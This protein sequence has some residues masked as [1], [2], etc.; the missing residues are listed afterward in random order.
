MSVDDPVGYLERLVQI[1]SHESVYEVRDFLTE[2]IEN[3]RVHPESGCVVATKGPETG[4]PHV[5]LNSHMDV[6]PPHLEYERDGN[7]L[8][9]RGVC[10]A[11]GSLAP[12]VAA[13][14]R[15]SPDSGKV[16]LV[17][18]PDEE[19]YSEG[20]YDFLSLEGESGDMAI[21]GEPTGLDVCNAARGSLKYV[22]ELEGSAA[23]AG[24]KD[25]GR[26]AVSCAAD[27]VGRLER[28][29]PL[30]DDY[31]GSTSQTVSWIEGGPV[32]EYTSQVPRQVRLFVNR[33]SVPPEEPADFKTEIEAELSDLDC[34]VTVRY[35]YQPNRFLEAFRVEPDEPVI[36]DLS[37]AVES[38][39]GECP[40]VRPFAVAAEASF[41]ARYMPVAIFG[42][43]MSM[44]EE[45]PI[46][47]SDREY[48]HA[49]EVATAADVLT[50]YLESTV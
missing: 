20:L 17:V 24:T 2:T 31:L 32:G 37:R 15:V 48:I 7:V 38:V 10:D 4:S 13:F 35:P 41:F 21:N 33:W 43:G 36:Q 25:S 27:A 9:G 29:N 11:K 45:G 1:P 44:D 12:L 5:F 50:E 39:T 23:H 40:E 47:H 34:D 49:D 8:R 42:P 46:A 14:S 3:A 16:T 18:S 26:S 30:S 22:V 19:T 6:V 28:M